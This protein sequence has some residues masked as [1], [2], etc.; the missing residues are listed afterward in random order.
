MK[1]I[2]VSFLIAGMLAPAVCRAQP[3]SDAPG[4]RGGRKG[5]QRPFQE[6][7]EAVDSDHD[8]FISKAEF[9]AMPRVTNLPEDKRANIFNRLDKDVDG[10]L[11]REELGRFGKPRDGENPPARRLWE[12]DA[13]RSGGVDFEEFKKGPLFN[14]LP[15]EKQL[16]VFRRLDTDGDGTITPKDNPEP[17]LKHPGEGGKPMEQDRINRK[18]DLNGD[19]ALSF[20]EFRAGNAVKNLTEDEQEDRFQMLDRNGDHQITTEDFQGEP[21]PPGKRGPGPDA[22]DKPAAKKGPAK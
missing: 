5:P 15:A 2:S 4:E 3:P 1:T 22:G 8:G 20:E 6:T 9:N 19:G 17:R 21:K 14:K 18:L 10:K 7:W 13:D 12:L 11:S 16:E